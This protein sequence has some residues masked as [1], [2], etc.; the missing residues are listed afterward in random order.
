MHT[1]WDEIASALRRNWELMRINWSV[2]EVWLVFTEYYW[3]ALRYWLSEGNG[4]H[5]K[6]RLNHSRYGANRYLSPIF[7]IWRSICFSLRSI[8]LSFFLSSSCKPTIMS[9]SFLFW[10]VSFSVWIFWR[11]TSRLASVTAAFVS[12]SLFLRPKAIYFSPKPVTSQFRLMP[13]ATACGTTMF[14]LAL[15]EL[16]HC[17]MHALVKFSFCA[18][19]ACVSHS[20][21][22]IKR[23][24]IFCST[25]LK[26]I[27]N[28]WCPLNFKRH[29]KTLRN[30]SKHGVADSFFKTKPP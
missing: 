23:S 26:R 8:T 2:I 30:A 6:A 24:T 25:I 4:Y 12:S 27:K 7:S 28:Y 1:D 14:R 18:S 11:S 22:I 16:R 17:E 3:S 20:Y 13:L 15:P 29:D 5:R 21:I 9:K 10:S 19:F